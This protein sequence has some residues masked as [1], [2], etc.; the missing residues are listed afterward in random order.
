MDTTEYF[1]LFL[2]ILVAFFFTN[3]SQT[4]EEQ[5][6]DVYDNYLLLP[7]QKALAV[8]IDAGGGYAYGTASGKETIEQ[9]KEDAMFQCSVRRKIYKLDDE[10]EIYMVN[11]KK[12][13]EE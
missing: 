8:A 5:F 4:F 11:N 1:R 13:T 6:P 7:P 3:C 10:C 9:A 12:V 2:L